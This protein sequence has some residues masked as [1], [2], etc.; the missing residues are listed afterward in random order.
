MAIDLVLAVASLVGVA[1]LFGNFANSGFNKLAT[2]F[3]PDASP[4]PMEDLGGF[5]VVL[6]IVGF[7]WG[8]WTLAAWSEG[9]TPGKQLLALKVVESRHGIDADFRRMFRR[10]AVFKG[11]VGNLVI[12]Y[13][14][15]IASPI[16]GGLLLVAAIVMIFVTPNR[17]GYW[18]LMAGTVVV[19]RDFGRRPWPPI[20]RSE[21]KEL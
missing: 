3:N 14:S 21:T 5:L 9:T 13:L 17:T 19:H 15:L 2:T 7:A 20:S 11:M 6:V 10:E 8:I 12:V 1:T 18:D 4:S 16:L